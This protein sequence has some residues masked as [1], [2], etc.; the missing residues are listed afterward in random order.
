MASPFRNNKKARKRHRKQAMQHSAWANQQAVA[1]TRPAYVVDAMRWLAECNIHM[2]Q[3]R[4]K[5]KMR[6]RT[7]DDLVL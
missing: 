5:K 6:R 4:R 2:A 3:S 7:G 1:G